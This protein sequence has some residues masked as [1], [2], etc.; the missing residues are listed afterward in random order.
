M[1]K[2]TTYIIVIMCILVHLQTEETLQ[3][4][5]IGTR[6]ID[7]NGKVI[8]LGISENISPIAV[9]F[10]DTSCPISNRYAPKLNK[11]YQQSNKQNVPFYGIISDPEISR[12]QAVE[13]QAQYKLQFPILFDSAG[14]L[15]SRLQ[16][17]TVPEAFVV[18]KEDEVAYRGRI[19]NRFSSVGKRRTVSTTNDLQDAILSVAKTGKSVIKNTK[20]IGCIFE[21]WEGK[22]E[23]VNYNRH[24]EPILRANCTSCHQPQGIGPFSLTTY[25]DAKRR[26]GMISYVAHEKIMPPWYAK[27]GFGS[28]RDEHRLSD[29]QISLLKKWAKNGRKKGLEEDKMPAVKIRTSKWALGKPDAIVTMPEPFDIP[30]EGEDIYRYFVVPSAFLEDKVIVALDFLPGNTQV[31]H[32]SIYYA[33]YSGKALQMDKN[34][35]QPGF[36]VFGKGGFMEANNQAFSIGGWAPGAAPY[37]LPSGYGID[38]PKGHDIVIEIHYHLNGKKGTDQSSIGFYFAKKPV[39]KFIDGFIMGTQQVNIPANE[40]NYQRR[41]VMDVPADM[42]VIDISPHMHYI[43]KD[44]KANIILP[45]GEKQPLLHIEK[46]DF[47]WQSNYVYRQPVFVPKGSQIE[48]FFSFDNSANNAANP[49]SPPKNIKWGWDSTQEMCELYFTIIAKD[50]DK[51]AIR[52]AS[53]SSWIRSANPKVKTKN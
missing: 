16:P 23:E 18:N 52:T 48:A 17:T 6:A 24:I 25:K 40:E 45:T 41:I 3:A 33:D 4:N 26:G 30:A 7:L 9:V 35:P 27:K 51:Q 42:K 12:S 28:F 19:D 34:D 8:K 11:I 43:G 39:T 38:L 50:R 31:V 2:F 22:I 5:I 29:R 21:A 15:A 53:Y 44:I 13:F 46:W 32:H 37:T 36:S 49:N 47:R 20:A 14:D 10:L 1:L